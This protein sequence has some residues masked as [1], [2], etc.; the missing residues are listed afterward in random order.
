[1]HILEKITFSILFILILNSCSE[2]SV[3]NTLD[4]SDKISKIDSSK[5]NESAVRKILIKSLNQVKSFSLIIVF[6]N[7][8]FKNGFVINQ[9]QIEQKT[10]INFDHEEII[11]G[12]QDENGRPKPKDLI[13]K[14]IIDGY[15]NGYYTLTLQGCRFYGAK[16]KN[17][18]DNKII[19]FEII[20][21]LYE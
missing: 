5:K 13:Y 18:K 6:D 3:K 9:E 15:V 7:E 1:M 14:E 17:V 20:N 8:D 2:P 12:S 19:D 10:S 16:Y 11:E 21:D 4:D